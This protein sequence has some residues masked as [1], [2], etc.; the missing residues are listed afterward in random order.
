M[1][2]IFVQEFPVT[3]V[4]PLPLCSGRP[5]TGWRGSAGFPT[6]FIERNPTTRASRTAA[7][8]DK[9]AKAV[10]DTKLAMCVPASR[11]VFICQISEDAGLMRVVSPFRSP[12]NTVRSGLADRLMIS[13]RLTETG[14]GHDAEIDRRGGAFA[15]FPGAGG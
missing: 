13:F 9:T 7:M 10:Q 4:S 3:A 6:D 14:D 8:L 5:R 15:S 2:E 11:E 12:A 1:D